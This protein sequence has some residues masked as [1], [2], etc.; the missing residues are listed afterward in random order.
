MVDN[1]VFVRIDDRL[2]HGQVVTQWIK[3]YKETRHILVVDDKTSKDPFMQTM[4]QLLIPKGITIEI[5][6]IDKA[7]EMLKAGMPKPTMIIAKVPDTVKALRDLGVDIDAFNIGGMGMSGL[8]KKFFQ[9]ISMDEH[10]KQIIQ[11]MVDDGVKI[12]IQIVPAQG[13]YDV[14]DLLKKAK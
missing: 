6:P 5:K 1:V 2:I 10:E 3:Q 9:N 13:C 12:T 14:S 4:F 8:R 7:A 11:E